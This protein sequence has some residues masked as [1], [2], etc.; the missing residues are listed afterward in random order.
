MA[1]ASAA[2]EVVAFAEVVS[3]MALGDVID[4][5][6]PSWSGCYVG[7]HH[8]HYPGLFVL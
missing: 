3:E 2:A 7:L 4:C 1:G 8:H 6:T 5:E